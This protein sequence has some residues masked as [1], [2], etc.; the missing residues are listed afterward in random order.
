MMRYI[1]TA[2]VSINVNIFLGVDKYIWFK[3]SSILRSSSD[4]V[5]EFLEDV[6]KSS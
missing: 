5:S 3:L 4:K 1:N 2:L 6:I